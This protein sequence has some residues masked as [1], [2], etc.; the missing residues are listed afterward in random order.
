MRAEIPSGEYFQVK[1]AVKNDQL[2]ILTQHPQGVTSDTEN[3]FVL[4]EEALQSLLNHHGQHVEIFLRIAGVKLPYA[5]HSLILKASETKVEEVREFEVSYEN[6]KAMGRVQQEEKLDN[7]SSFITSDA[8][9][10]EQSSPDIPGE[11]EDQRFDPMADAPD[12]S[13]YTTLNSRRPL[14][15]IV[16][17][18]VVAAIPILGGAA[19]LLTR[20]C[21]M[22]ECKEI[23]TAEDLDKSWQRL[24]QTSKSESELTTVQQQLGE[25]TT[26]LKTIPSWSRHYQEAETLATNLSRHSET[27]NKIIKAFSAASL[28]TQKVKLR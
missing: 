17:G 6:E 16:F 9:M 24:I 5:K 25:A 10:D 28:A 23:Q 12:L 2:M 22:S 14:K 15:P 21:V 3:I 27:I 13:Y 1:C 4:L 11:S 18:L 20:P 7:S 19:Y 26:A 8:L